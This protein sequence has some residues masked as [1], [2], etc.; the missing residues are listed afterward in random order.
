MIV[1]RTIP[2]YWGVEVEPEDTSFLTRAHLQEVLP[3]YR[4]STRAFRIRVSHKHWLHLG[5]YRY[6]R[7]AAGKY[8]IPARPGDIGRWGLDRE[9][10]QG[11]DDVEAEEPE[12]AEEGE[13]FDPSWP[14]DSQQALSLAERGHHDASGIDT[15]TPGRVVEGPTPIGRRHGLGAVGDGDALG[16]V[17]GSDP[18][19]A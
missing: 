1:V 2:V 15:W 8:G 9:A 3:P 7:D 13:E 18:G 12:G 5:L 14:Y 4:L 19:T 16:D 11:R 17:P 10:D 6:D